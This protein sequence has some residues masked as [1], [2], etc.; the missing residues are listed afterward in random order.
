M[1]PVEEITPNKF[2]WIME[3]VKDITLSKHITKTSISWTELKTIHIKA[4]VVEYNFDACCG[5]IQRF[6][7][8]FNW[9]FKIVFI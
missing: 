2:L 9:V 5:N 3:S 1:E 6:A 8:R 7:N 4:D